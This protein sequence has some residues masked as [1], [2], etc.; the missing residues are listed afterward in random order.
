MSDDF[1]KSA[2]ERALERADRIEVPEEK[3]KEMEH[4]SKGEQIAAEFFQNPQFEMEAALASYDTATRKY[5]V[6]TIETIFLQNLILPK[7]E[8]D[9]TNNN[10]AFEGLSAL[11]QNKAAIQQAQEQLD[12]LSNYYMQAVKQHF[13]QLRAE[14]QQ[15]VNQAM[16]QQAGM[17]ATSNVNVE[18]TP[19]FQE[20]WRRISAQLDTE[21]GKAL[22][23]L[24]EQIRNL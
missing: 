7:Q 13:E 6:K 19:E 9:V 8:A 11:K 17:N 12:N 5:I 15:A 16:Q 3:L 22:S 20:N 18:Q 24:K 1:M 2:L 4:R 23:Q 21:Y 14:L 10:K